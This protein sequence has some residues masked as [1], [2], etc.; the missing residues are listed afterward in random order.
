[1][2][3]SRQPGKL[4]P[5]VLWRV[6]PVATLVLLVTWMSVSGIAQNELRNE[7]QTRLKQAAKNIARATG[8][9]IG[10]IEHAARNL[11]ANNL[12]AGSLADIQ[13]TKGYVK[14]FFRSLQIS[15]PDGAHITLADYRGR[16]LAA[17]GP[18]RSYKDAS[19]VKTVMKGNNHFQVNQ[20]GML[21]AA[22]MMLE[23]R[24]EGMLVVEYGPN[25]VS[26]ILSAA[27]GGELTLLMNN[28]GHVLYSSVPEIMESDAALSVIQD[29]GWIHVKT[30]VQGY[31]DISI[32]EAVTEAAALASVSKISTIMLIGII[33]ALFALVGGIYLAVYLATRPLTDFVLTL[34]KIGDQ[35]GL[36]ARMPP[37][38]SAEF[39]QLGN[40]FNN[41]LSR[42]EQTVTSR[43]ALT[44]EVAVRKRAELA[45]QKSEAE[46]EAARQRLLDAIEA[47]PSGFVLFDRDDQLVLF[48]KVAA[49][50]SA[51]IGL[52]FKPGLAFDDYLA[53]NMRFQF[54]GISEDEFQEKLSINK[55]AHQRLL[56]YGETST[57]EREFAPGLWVKRINNRTAEGGSLGILTDISD[58]K[59]AQE[60]LENRAA[61]LARSNEEL[62]QFAYLA[63]HDMQEPIRVIGSFCDLLRLRYADKLDEE[64]LEFID[65]AVD[66]ARRMRSL[67][68]DLLTYSRVGRSEIKA[69]P[70]PLS[71]V[72]G[73][74]CERL[75]S[76]IE[77]ENATVSADELPTVRGDMTLLTQLFQNLVG[78]AI[79]FHGDD[80]PE[81]KITAK[82][83]GGNWEFSVIDNGIGIEL[84][85]EG[86][87]FQMFQRL[88][89]RTEFSGNGLGLALCKRVVERHG[90]DIWIAPTDS[91]GTTI[92]FSIPA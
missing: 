85:Y 55:A 24:P 36:S 2:S 9:Q 47:M 79:K 18:S 43:D 74:V 21:V 8:Y 92:Q 3:I 66:G 13:E 45:L 72:V 81:V 68:D 30:K 31:P 7:A 89:N 50:L 17:N 19:W 39:N 63:S 1:M 71:G 58:M 53:A 44:E 12:L 16:P 6:L 40:T 26:E 56:A 54:S 32:I 67:I 42:L 25:A 59:L 73:E 61:E 11:A 82:Q 28:S 20:S 90:G 34:D 33:V 37:A 83:K 41:T 52:K 48:N 22:P 29:R 91:P 60:T 38:K 23:G 80:P 10:E 57:L 49:D 15:G 27:G 77:E 51:H 5:Q 70:V 62:E 84:K 4:L 64:G 35:A 65:Y 69:Q 86:R 88:H 78:N 14:T 76:R 75:S 87:V 46:T